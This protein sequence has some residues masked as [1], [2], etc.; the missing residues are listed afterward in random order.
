M[1]IRGCF[2]KSK[3]VLEQKSW[4]NTALMQR[5]VTEVPLNKRLL[6]VARTVKST[7]SAS[8]HTHSNKKCIGLKVIYCVNGTKG[9]PVP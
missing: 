7:R 4:G 1:R 5:T 8:R 3:G 2:S 6:N 9:C